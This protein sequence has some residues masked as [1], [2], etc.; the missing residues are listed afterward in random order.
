[1]PADR[2]SGWRGPF[3]VNADDPRVLVPKRSAIGSTVNFAHRRA[4]LALTLA[5]GLPLTGAIL[6][7]VLAR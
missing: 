3:Y 1:M 4:W 7:L 2:P 6:A 5:A